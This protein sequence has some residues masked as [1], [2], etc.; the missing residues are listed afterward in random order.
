MGLRIY[1]A[2]PWIEKAQM[3]DISARI[4]NAGH[5]ITYK[6]WDVEDTPESDLTLP[7]LREQATNDVLGV[8]NADILVV[9]NTAKSEG[10]ALEQGIA[11]AGNKP[12][13]I[14]G[15]RGEFSKNVF[16]YLDNYRWVVD[17]DSAL[18]VLETCH[19][20]ISHEGVE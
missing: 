20:L 2:A 14:V 12:I 4:E 10:K 5:Q 8:R 9:L 16:H 17:V 18:A 11:I 19:W 3:S 15:R 6:W 1:I 7:I 13:I